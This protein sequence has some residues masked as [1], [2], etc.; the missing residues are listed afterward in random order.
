MVVLHGTI[1]H[2]FEGCFLKKLVTLLEV[3][4][5]KSQ[6]IF[7]LFSVNENMLSCW[8]IIDDNIYSMITCALIPIIETFRLV[9]RIV[10]Q[11]DISANFE[12][13][14]IYV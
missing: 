10:I 1:F 4:V 9:K 2:E 7:V 12:D 13:V 6:P 14:L 5:N 11:A 3:G 8:K